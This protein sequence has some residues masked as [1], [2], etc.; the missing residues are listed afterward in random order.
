MFLEQGIRFHQPFY[1][2]LLGTIVV[3]LASTV[4]QLPMIA[5]VYLFSYWEKLPF[6]EGQDAIMTFFDQNT[7]LF[8]LLLPFVLIFIALLWFV[9][10]W[11]KQPLL[12]LFT[13]RPTLDWS[14]VRFSFVMWAILSASLILLE[15][16]LNPSDFVWNFQPLPFLILC[17]VVLLLIPIQ[18]T[19]E[20]LLCRGYLMQGFAT[21]SRYKWVPLLL[22]SLLFGLFHFANP[23]VKQMGYGI[24][25]YYIGT[26]LFLGILTLMDEGMELAIGFHAANNIIG[27]ILITADWSVFQT[28]AL[29]KDLSTPTFGYDVFLPIL[30]IYPILL[31]IFVRRYGWSQW[32]SKL[33]GPLTTI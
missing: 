20:E 10:K 22:T 12:T 32:K 15:Y 17:G 28:P 33:L 7:T 31:S 2:Y 9:K 30:L 24:L 18:T 29:L 23:E 1:K 25:W 3:L 16:I 8:F 13:T 21:F 19:A 4:G 11:H 14:R 5:A 26:G 27:A 6:P